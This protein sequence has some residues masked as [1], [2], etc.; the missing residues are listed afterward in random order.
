MPPR[1]LSDALVELIA[2]RF[3]VLGQPLRV[4]LIDLLKLRGET[5]VQALADE[6]GAT[7]QNMSK[8]LGV[9]RQAGILARRREG[10]VVWY[11]L[12]DEDAFALVVRVGEETTGRLQ[13]LLDGD[14]TEWDE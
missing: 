13:S 11:T 1:P 6:L 4:R 12:V 2:H 7:Q 3:R 5:T 9:L 14:D 10:R 8:H